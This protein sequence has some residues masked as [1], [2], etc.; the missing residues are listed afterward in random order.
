VALL[1]AWADDVALCAGGDREVLKRERPDDG[2]AR[3]TR[4]PALT[5]VTADAG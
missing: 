4:A 1:R 5:S 2:L 3:G